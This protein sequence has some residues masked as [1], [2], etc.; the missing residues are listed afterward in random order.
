[1][2]RGRGRGKKQVV[3]APND[4]SGSGKDEKVMALKRRGRPQKPLKEDSEEEFEEQNEKMEEALKIPKDVKN[5]VE[6]ENGSKRKRSDQTKDEDATGSKSCTTTDDS[7]KSVGF[8]PI[9]S[10]RKN[11]PRRAA[12][13]VVECWGS[14]TEHCTCK[15][16]VLSCCL[17]QF[18]DLVLQ[19]L[20]SNLALIIKLNLIELNNVLQSL[21]SNLALQVLFYISM[22]K[23]FT[24]QQLYDAYKDHRHSQFQKLS[25]SSFSFGNAFK[26]LK[27]VGA[28]V[29][30][31]LQRKAWHGPLSGLRHAVC[32]N[33][34]MDA[35]CK[36]G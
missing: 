25:T 10:R 16:S 14:W 3:N 35:I 21:S 12:E 13:A 6:L 15:S 1:M 19:S 29:C 8:R 11:K 18:S 30:V 27:V 9:G 33:R 7:M 31:Y 28:K 36:V 5:E 24:A 17:Q 23:L 32:Y 34:C 4:D 26:P 20:S 2:G 22:I